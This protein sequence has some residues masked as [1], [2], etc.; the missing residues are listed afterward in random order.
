MP[1][2]IETCS[3]CGKAA[4]SGQHCAFC[5]PHQF[6]VTRKSQTVALI[7]RDPITESIDFD[8]IKLPLREAFM[9]SLR[10]G[11]YWRKA[12]EFQCNGKIYRW[13]RVDNG[14]KS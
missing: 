9:V 13:E 4:G 7:K 11:G 12:G 2:S 5:T 3:K 10:S 8:G 1:K 14:H 6:H